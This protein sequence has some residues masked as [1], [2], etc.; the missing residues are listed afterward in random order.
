MRPPKGKGLSRNQEMHKQDR[1]KTNNIP[2]RQG[3]KQNHEIALLVILEEMKTMKR[4]GLHK[5]GT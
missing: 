4:Q 3:A 1:L 2:K 5:T